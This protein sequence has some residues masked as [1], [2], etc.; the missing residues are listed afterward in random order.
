MNWVNL[1][2]VLIAIGGPV[3]GR[4]MQTLE[5]QR[6]ARQRQKE[7]EARRLEALRTGRLGEQERVAVT[8]SPVGAGP[9]ASPHNTA[10]RMQELARKRREQ[11]EELRRRQ[12]AARQRTPTRAGPAGQTLPPQTGRP[13]PT[14]PGQQRQRPVRPPQ[15]VPR[16]PQQ[17]P[18][19]HPQQR[20]P[21]GPPR[22]PQTRNE[23][24]P[25]P[26]RQPPAAST[27]PIEANAIEGSPIARQGLPVTE[28]QTGTA[29]LSLMGRR[30]TPADW[31]RF[32]IGR[33]MLGPPIALRAPEDEF[34]Q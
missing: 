14:V 32:I 31:R 19:P 34:V 18:Q 27:P 21:Q 28:D 10:D 5:K 8:I 20:R 1:V 30:M 15:Q 16:Q 2:I 33:E 12:Q 29:R 26:I 4:L 25:S 7:A 22:P 3:L 9:N 13:A 6:K 24:T 11:L 23:R 17:R